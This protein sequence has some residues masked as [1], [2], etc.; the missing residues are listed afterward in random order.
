MKKKLIIIVLMLAFV[1]LSTNA[2]AQTES[3]SFQDAITKDTDGDAVIDAIDI[4]VDHN[5]DDAGGGLLVWNADFLLDFSLGGAVVS[6]DIG[7]GDT[8]GDNIFRITVT[9]TLGT[10]AT[11]I[12]VGYL[13][14]SAR[15]IWDV[16]GGY[17]LSFANQS[18][19]DGA[20]P[21]IKELST[22]D[23]NNDGYADQLKVKFSETLNNT[24]TPTGAALESI[25][26]FSDTVYDGATLSFNTYATSVA[27]DDV[28]IMDITNP[29]TIFS[30]YT[31]GKVPTLEV[32]DFN[33]TGLFALR[34]NSLNANLAVHGTVFTDATDLIGP[35][36]Q[37]SITSQVSGVNY[38]D[39][40]FADGEIIDGTTV[41][42]ADFD[43][44]IDGVGP[45]NPTATAVLGAPNQ[46]VVRLTTTTAVPVDIDNTISTVQLTGIEII[47]DTFGNSNKKPVVTVP[48]DDGISPTPIV[49]TTVDPIFEGALTQTV[50]VTYDEAMNAATQPDIS[51]TSTNFTTNGGGWTVGNTVWTE[52]FTHDG[53]EEEL[54]DHAAVAGGQATDVAGN[55]GN[56]ADSP[57]FEVDTKKPIP[58]VTVLVDPI[59]EG[60]LTQT[61]IV[62]YDEAMQAT[63]P[64]ISFTSTHFTSDAVG[65]WTVGNTVWTETFTHDGTEEEIISETVTVAGS[66]AKDVAGNTGTTGD[67]D[68]VLDTEKPTPTV[69]LSVD[70][71]NLASSFTQVV[72]VTYDEEIN[73]PAGPTIDFANSTHFTTVGDG[74][75]TVSN[76]VWTE[77]F[78]HDGTTEQYLPETVT[79]VAGSVVDM[80]GN[81]SN[82]GNN[83]FVL[84]LKKPTPTV[85]I[86]DDPISQIDL[87]Q[88]VTVTFDEAMDAT[89]NPEITF[90]STYFTAGVGVWS[91]GNTVFTQTFT[92]SGFEESI[93]ADAAVVTAG[94]ATDITGNTCNGASSVNFQIYT[95]RPNV[96]LVTVDPT[97]ISD[98]DA[99]NNFTV[100]I[101]YDQNMGVVVDPTLVFNPDV[102]TSGTLTLTGEVW[103][104]NTQFEATYSI[105]DVNEYQSNI[106]II[107]TGANNAFGNPQNQYTASD[108]FSVDTAVPIVQAVTGTPSVINDAQVNVAKG[109]FVLSVQYNE[110]M[111]TGFNP[112]I[113]FPVENPSNTITFAS[114]YWGTTTY[115]N[116][117]YYQTYNLVDVGETVLDIDVNVDNN[118]EDVAGNAPVAAQDFVDVFSIDTENPIGTIAVDTDPITDID[119]VQVVTVTYDQQMDP[120]SSPTI[121]FAGNTGA[122]TSPV[123]STG[124]WSGGNVWTETF[125]VADANEENTVTVSSANATDVNGNTEAA[126]VDATFEIDTRNPIGTIVVGTDPIWEGDLDQVVTIT[127][128]EAMD[129][130]SSPTIA[131]AG[132]TGAINT[133]SDGAW[134]VVNTVWTET[135]TVTNAGEENTV[136]VSSSG[137][138]DVVGNPEGP[139]V[140][141]TFEIDTKN[142]TPTVTVS[143]DPIYEGALTQTVTV[144]YD[145]AMDNTTSPTITTWGSTNYTQGVG[146]W[147]ATNQIWTQAATHDG[148]L[149]RIDPASINVIGAKDVVGNTG[150]AG[151]VDYLLDTEPPTSSA[152]SATY[153]AVT[154]AIDVLWT[155]ND[156]SGISQVELYVS[157]NDGAYSLAGT[158]DTGNLAGTFNYALTP[159]TAEATY[160]FYTIA[161]DVPG[162]VETD[163]VPSSPDATVTVDVV[164]TE[165][166]ITTTPTSPTQGVYFTVN[167]E[168]VD[169]GG[170]RD[171]DWT[172]LV[173][174]SSNYPENVTLPALSEFPASANGYASYENC[175]SNEAMTDLGINVW[176][177]P[178]ANMYSTSDPIIVQL[179]TVAAPTNTVVTDVP[180][181]Q[182]GWINLAYTLSVN[183]PFHSTPVNPPINYYVLERDF[184]DAGGVVDWEVVG[185]INLYDPS[186]G[187]DAS[188]LMQVPASDEVYLYQMAAVYNPNAGL[189]DGVSKN[190]SPEI[191]YATE[192]PE[193]K[194][195]IQSPWADCGSAAAKDNIEAF[196]N[197]KVFLE[198]PYQ[199]GG[200]M[201]ND[202]YTAGLLPGAPAN[203]VDV[204]TVELRSTTT[205][206][207]VKSTDAYVATD[208]SIINASGE[209]S[210][211]FYYTTDIYFTEITLVS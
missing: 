62:T 1:G 19:L 38:I 89:D 205:G 98:A 20:S 34:D 66:V 153:N 2:F 25:F 159:A 74:A 61:V 196:A 210:L 123:P 46:N 209:K 70:P 97:T 45:A 148:T 168:A 156:A 40:Y 84:D 55:P 64:D 94:S 65:T 200:T 42:N 186:G 194:G 28:F 108:I 143:V 3:S 134:S 158:D 103:N 147:D 24:Y 36:I 106:D 12:T 128:D 110:P 140:N 96:T 201:N 165:F 207:T 33:N 81:A 101:D 17:V 167:V 50:T 69:L 10:G 68:F 183:D 135:F 7:T 4:Y 137:A 23:T 100:T 79:A 29:T 93:P 109:Q 102:V 85:N 115:G 177:Y 199:S 145:E 76:T 5:L 121:S 67:T 14:N 91:S 75:W 138:K 9:S 104:T 59:Y 180:N 152:T 192:N 88:T 190:N 35:V 151:V 87:T 173:N 150:T 99:G 56:A 157:R 52:T 8:A 125:D 72:T 116:D 176:D 90:T 49:A 119:L 189:F 27:T 83:T 155:A 60:A 164:A 44:I 86:S 105:A 160:D 18:V 161:T 120:A 6:T 197:F 51:F 166:A 206:A 132:N 21:V 130:A 26:D 149:E 208:G 47:E 127:Y 170:N 11:G 139:S 198:G 112:T 187:D 203:A 30:G 114:E 188:V 129:A 181:D 13:S 95:I 174:F 122:I 146:A 124:A 133:Q 43:V 136:T 82:G 80:Y 71:M 16:E 191:V 172:G 182:G 41:D 77:S 57:D 162:N 73:T 32:A 107:I 141:D 163:F 154:G 169:A 142:P 113:T 211:P 175:I 144:T 37:S 48:T 193:T 118:V 92:H 22:I 111:N 58:T 39:V 202:L 15:R 31:T 171:L 178:D 126:S 78:T 204:I 131:F 54:D 185:F 53:T 117:T 195:S 63:A 184:D 179:G